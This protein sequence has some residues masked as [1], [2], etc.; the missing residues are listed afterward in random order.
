MADLSPPLLTDAMPQHV[1]W[2]QPSSAFVGGIARSDITAPV[3]VR[4]YNWGAGRQEL[5][6][7]V[8]RPLTATVLAISDPGT[9]AG[10]DPI[11]R[12]LISLDLGWW[13]DSSSYLRLL[14]PLMEGLEATADQIL[15]HLV[16]T[17]AG[18]SL[19]DLGTPLPG[20]DLLASYHEHLVESILTAA[21]DARQQSASVDLT[22]SYG[23][24]DLAVVRNLPCG[25]RD[26]V[27]FDPDQDADDTLLLGRLT[28]AQSGEVMGT[29]LNYAA[30]PTTLAHHNSLLSPDYVGAAREVLEDATGAPCLFLQG[31]S[32]ELSPREQY[33]PGTQQ[34]DINGRILGH[35]A[36]STLLNMPEPGTGLVFSGVI[37]SG[38]PLGIWES[39]PHHGSPELSFGAHHVQLPARQNRSKWDHIDPVAARERR[40]RAE[41]LTEGYLQ[42][43]P[44]AGL[45]A[46]HPFWVW[47][48]GDAALVAHPGEAFSLLQRELRRRHPEIPLLVA[49]L[50]GGPGFV[51]L[52]DQASYDRDQ[53]Q[54]W[55]TPLEPGALE[56]LVSAADQQL[57]TLF[58]ATP[59]PKGS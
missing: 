26:V 15:I 2:A 48:L 45:H 29:I 11:W 52:P 16:H 3:G 19:S 5:A 47:R 1:N 56:S 21:R 13:R 27:A 59:S 33:G 39:A 30:H 24:C 51:Y 32:G 22:W 57:N 17:H 58:A 31:A 46:D 41:V 23:H 7:G 36:Y 54:V 38:A 20:A 14:E 35:A 6:T 49:N 34:A 9:L 18:P 55:Q 44:D 37:E 50:T 42:R 12:Y 8:H 4:A 40:R 10:Q 53:Y 43:D 25:D 28:Q